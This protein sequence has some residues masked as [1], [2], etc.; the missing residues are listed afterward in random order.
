VGGG[1]LALAALIVGGGVL[2][3]TGW[4]SGSATSPADGPPNYVDESASA[5]ID[6]TYAGGFEFFVGGGVAAFD[7]ND[8]GRDELYFA[9]GSEPAAL[10]RNESPV[11]GELRFA[12]Q[13]SPV[14]DLTAVTGAYPLDLDSDGQI[15][16]AVLRRGGNVVLRGLGM[17]SR[18]PT[19]ARHRRW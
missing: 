5:G 3:V 13:S 4:P 6:H 1:A 2:V 8:D 16:L 19:I 12:E 11:G 14:T 17:S 15:D 9:G 18:M 10:Y 7:C